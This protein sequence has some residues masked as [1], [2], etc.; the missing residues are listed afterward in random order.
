MQLLCTRMR[1]G[2]KNFQSHMGITS[3]ITLRGLLRRTTRRYPRAW[4]VLRKGALLCG[5][6]F[7][8]MSLIPGTSLPLQTPTKLALLA[9]YLP[10]YPVHA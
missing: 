8:M 6:Y 9:T 3:N 2:F 1:S 4:G 5:I 7:V 10:L